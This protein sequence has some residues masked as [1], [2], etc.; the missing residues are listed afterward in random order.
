[1]ATYEK[2][3]AG[4]QAR[5]R[6]GGIN[7]TATFRTKAEAQAWATAIEN[8]LSSGRAGLAPN[9]TFGEL[10][11]R[12]AEEVSP[13]KRGGRWEQLRIALFIRE[14]TSLCDTKLSNFN[15]E[16]VAAWRD[17]RLKDVSELSVIREW[18]ILQNACSVAVK[19]WRWLSHNPMLSVKKPS[20]PAARNRRPTDDETERLLLATGYDYNSPP[21]TM[22]ARVGAAWLFAIETGM[23]AGEICNI[24][25]EHAHLSDR[26]IHLPKTKNGHARDVPLS[27]EALRIFEQV[28]KA[29]EGSEYVFAIKAATLDAMFRKAKARALIEDLHFHDSRREA[30]TR[31]SKKVDVMTLAKISGH[32]DLRILQ[33]TYYAPKMSEYVHLLD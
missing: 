10:L 7:K 19:E 18:A 3:K 32:R 4:W 29:T 23:R 14:Y 33:N 25:L 16:T 28:M 6:K 9:R 27:K 2:R 13:S 12:Y 8:D 1:M 5:V 20:A 24:T 30:L 21:D 15:T 17:D 26:I 11:K 22:M 31:L